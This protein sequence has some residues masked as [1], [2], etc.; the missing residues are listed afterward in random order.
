MNRYRLHWSGR[1][2]VG[3]RCSRLGDLASNTCYGRVYTFL[4]KTML[5][6]LQEVFCF[7]M[8]FGSNGQNQRLQN[9]NPGVQVDSYFL[10][11]GSN[12]S[13]RWLP[14]HHTQS[15][16]SIPRYTIIWL[17]AHQTEFGGDHS[18]RWVRNNQVPLNPWKNCE[19][20]I[21]PSPAGV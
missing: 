19:E 2:F 6:N 16:F 3:I 15:V 21:S 18:L 9:K 10:E 4:M 7:C 8:V 14:N 13:F 12:Y 11:W 1:V 5:E 20:K 17:S